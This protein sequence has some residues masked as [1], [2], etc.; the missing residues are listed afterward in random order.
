MCG[1]SR[2]IENAAEGLLRDTQQPNN[3]RKT[4]RRSVTVG[5]EHREAPQLPEQSRRLHF[6][7]DEYQDGG[8]SQLAQHLDRLLPAEVSHPNVHQD[9]SRPFFLDRLKIL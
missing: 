3:L 6:G 2:N 1:A 7:V 8:G 5:L 9:D 4:W